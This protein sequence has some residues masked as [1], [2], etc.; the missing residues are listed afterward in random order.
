VPV[1]S[2]TSL[3]LASMYRTGN[4]IWVVGQ[5]AVILRHH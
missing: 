3:N 1:A 5:N 4:T 2:G